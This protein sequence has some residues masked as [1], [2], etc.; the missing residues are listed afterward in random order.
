L[1]PKAA[2]DVVRILSYNCLAD[3]F[4][5]TWS[6]LYP[7]L[8]PAHA[9]PEYRLPLA[10]QDILAPGADVI[11]LQEVDGRWY[12]RFWQPAMAAAGYAGRHT[13]KSGAG[14]EGAALFVRR[15]AYDIAAVRDIDL[16]MALPPSERGGAEKNDD[17]DADA[18]AEDEENEKGA[19]PAAA[20]QQGELP[21]P[22]P[23]LAPLLAAQPALATALR[24]VTTVA[25]LALL[26]PVRVPA[27]DANRHT[28][29]QP[30][31]L[32]VANT[33]L[34]FH[35]RA[36]HVRLLQ[37]HALLRAAAAFRAE[38]QSSQSDADNTVRD[39]SHSAAFVL[40]G[41]LNAEAADG[42]VR[43]LSMGTLGAG[44]G[45]W[46]RGAAFSWGGASSRAAAAA[47]AREASEATACCDDEACAERVAGN[48][49]AAAAAA[50]AGSR[51][52]RL[53]AWHGGRAAAAAAG[54]L[55]GTAPARACSLQAR[56]KS[57][58]EDVPIMSASDADVAEA[59]PLT[60][61]YSTL[62]AHL[63][64]GCTFKTCPAV[65]AWHLRRVT[66]AKAGLTLA[67][68]GAA[69]A[70]AL[71]ALSALAA[72]VEADADAAVADQASIAAAAGEGDASHP[73]PQLPRDANGFSAVPLGVGATL[74]H[75]WH[76]ASGCGSPAWTNYVGGFDAVLD[77]V[78]YDADKLTAEKWMPPPPLAAVIKE[79]ALPNGQFP[80]DHLPQCCD[81]KRRET[82]ADDADANSH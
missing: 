53:E 52:A 16:R 17:A 44:D 43:Y 68:G 11:G 78:W 24:R 26:V 81:L 54:L 30:P 55:R 1:G 13:P 15:A 27:S 14:G 59:A 23:G 34:F 10:L 35:P 66:G 57:E 37:T 40:C 62:A 18:D 51:A 71:Q 60:R 72:A 49:V 3:A 20:A 28:E 50:R 58:K 29:P 65:A 63:R 77:Y 7:Y 48:A 36:G 74:A 61:V 70:A 39:A 6:A 12:E 9:A 5:H 79:T 25:Q 82:H 41:D 19:T 73:P 22:P 56:K 45:E 33:H 31:P 38:L 69:A 64:G 67:P 75:P 2:S 76:M 8:A 21:P 46:A 42:P 32:L 4:A 80:S 47:A